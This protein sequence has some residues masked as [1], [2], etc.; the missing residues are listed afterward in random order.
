MRR[1]HDVPLVMAIAKLR[2]HSYMAT[3][4]T[5]AVRTTSLIET[6]SKTW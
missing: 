4:L 3:A 6:G 5:A 1:L 2:R